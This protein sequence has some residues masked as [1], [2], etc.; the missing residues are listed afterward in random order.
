VLTVAS[1][2]GVQTAAVVVLQVPNIVAY[3]T[4]PDLARPQLPCPVIRL[5]S[6]MDSGERYALRAKTELF[7]ALKRDVES[8]TPPCSHN[9][10]ETLS[11]LTHVAGLPV[12]TRRPNQRNLASPCLLV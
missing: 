1:L 3:L 8:E 4:K 5:P 2:I 7:L 12:S 9:F 11:H 6:H 10:C